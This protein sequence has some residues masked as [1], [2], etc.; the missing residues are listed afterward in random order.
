V[1]LI[2]SHARWAHSPRQNGYHD[3][4]AVLVVLCF[5]AL[6]IVLGVGLDRNKS[7]NGPEGA[8]GRAEFVTIQSRVLGREMPMDVF[9]PP[10]YDKSDERY[11]VLYMLHGMGGTNKEWNNYGLFAQAES[12]MQDGEIIP[13]IIV[14]PQ[15]DYGY[16]LD[17]AEGGPQWGDYLTREIVS[18]VDRRYRTIASGW[19]RAVGGLSMGADGALQVAMNYPG[20]FSVVGAHS[21]VLKPFGD[22]PPFFGD[23]AYFE[24]HWPTT[25]V[26]ANPNFARSLRISIDV[27]DTD[28]WLGNAEAF[29]DVLTA[30]DI[31]HDFHV[32]S[33]EHNAEYWTAHVA[34][35]LR[36]YSSGLR[37]GLTLAPANAR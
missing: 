5:S 22:A 30:L 29:H 23:L 15:G 8:N 19:A 13:F 1:R 16:W 7:S 9:L 34:D 27:G 11:A 14:L 2:R 28:I 3:Y 10:G 12:M 32:W 36:F 24:R 37:A 6:L 20:T 25:L 31:S 18:E 35:N 21:P 4:I 33:G 26:Q 17:H